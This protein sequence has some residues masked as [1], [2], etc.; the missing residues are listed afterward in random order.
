MAITETPVIL[1][2]DQVR[3]AL[4]AAGHT[5]KAIVDGDSLHVTFPTVY[6]VIRFAAALTGMYLANRAGERRD[7]YVL[8]EAAAEMVALLARSWNT[9]DECLS[10]GKALTWDSPEPTALMLCLCGVTVRGAP[11]GSMTARSRTPTAT[12]SPPTASASPSST[13]R[14]TTGS[15]SRSPP[16]TSPKPYP[17]YGPRSPPSPATSTTTPPAPA[18]PRR[19]KLDTN[20]QKLATKDR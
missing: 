18:C 19:L 12:C 14:S 5:G 7:R 8:D 16:P 15:W 1:E 2:A 10:E 13:P 9:Y 17:N 11:A 6:G 4:A 3:F 20:V